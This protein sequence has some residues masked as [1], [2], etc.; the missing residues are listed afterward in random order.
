M[1]RKT[2]VECCTQ[3]YTLWK[4]TLLLSKNK[5][6]V[7]PP[8]NPSG[9]FHSPYY[10][11]KNIR[12][13]SHLLKNTGE[14]SGGNLKIIHFISLSYTPYFFTLYTLFLIFINSH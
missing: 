7:E 8:R 10:I 11:K 12:E 6:K 2:Q 3:N 14:K 4:V 13:S 1:E 9:D 5:A